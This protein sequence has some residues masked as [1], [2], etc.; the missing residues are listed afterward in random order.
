MTD[1]T[2]GGDGNLNV[3]YAR[4]LEAFLKSYNEKKAEKYKDFN[5]TSTLGKEG[6]DCACH[7]SIR[8]R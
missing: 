8:L 1:P 3:D 6:K 7:V 5:L 4:T 2:D